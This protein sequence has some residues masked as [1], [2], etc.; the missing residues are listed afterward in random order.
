MKNYILMNEEGCI[1]C[2]VTKSN[3]RVARK[4]FANTVHGT[5]FIIREFDENGN[6]LKQYTPKF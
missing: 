4:Y 5:G 2:R 6:F 1:F 3:Y